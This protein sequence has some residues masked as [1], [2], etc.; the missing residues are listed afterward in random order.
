MVIIMKKK[1][2]LLVVAIMLMVTLI[3]LTT[4]AKGGSLLP[5]LVEID[6]N[7]FEITKVVT[8]VNSDFIKPKIEYWDGTY[9]G[10]LYEV[11]R[12][13]RNFRWYV[14]YRGVVCDDPTP[15]GS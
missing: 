10:M 8:Y 12:E 3:P 13:M 9:Y 2:S 4:H 7:C 1:L 11:N 14:T 5:E 6:A 15:Y